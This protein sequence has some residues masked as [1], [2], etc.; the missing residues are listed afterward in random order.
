MSVI[1][2]LALLL[3]AS[4]SVSAAPPASRLFAQHPQYSDVAMSPDGRHLAIATPVDKR[5]DLVVLDLAGKTEPKRL[6]Y[7]TN[8]HIIRPQFVSDTRIVVGKGRKPDYLEGTVSIGELNATNIDLSEPK[9]LFAYQEDDGNRKGRRKDQGFARVM[10]RLGRI[11]NDVLVEFQSWDRSDNSTYIYRVDAGTGE[12]KLID[13]VRM[14]NAWVDADHDGRPRFAFAIDENREYDIRYRPTPESDWQDLP[15][16][17]AG[18]SMVLLAFEQDNN[19]AYASISD[20]G[21]PAALYRV[22]FKSGTREKLMANGDFDVGSLM[23]A[24]F[25]KTPFAIYAD[26]PKPSVKYLDPTSEWAKLHAGLMK[27]FPGNLV[28]FSE[29]SRDEGKVLLAVYGDRNPGQYYLLDRKDNSLTLVYELFESLPPE[30][31]A[32]MRPIE[33]GTPDGV[34]LN[35]FLTVPTIGNA[36]FPMIVM[37]HGGPFGVSDHWGF[38]SDVQFLASRGYAVLQV[39]FRGSGGRGDKF[40]R[41]GFR[42]WGGKMMDDIAAGTYWAIAEKIADPE[43]ICTYGTSFGGYAAMMQPIRY[44]DLYRCAVGYVGVYDLNLMTKTG[45]INDTKSGR[46]YIAEAIGTDEKS[47]ADQSPV[48][49]VDKLKVP[50]LLIHGKVDHRVPIAHLDAL[51]SALKNAG[52]PPE[53]LVKSAEAH[54]FYSVDNRIELYDTLERFLAKHIGKE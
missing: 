40:E 15:S 37:A 28:A 4:A 39:N 9:A 24:G 43:R 46:N 54:G 1:R 6:R 21:E 44:P 26:T 33:V 19:M 22:D 36:P 18:L 27:R 10:S 38:D 11:E 35:G 25:D 23:V 45:D 48:D 50:V 49:L 14:Y 30:L 47:L 41:S 32:P 42:E 17:I 29:F 52:R 5:T 20:N 12:R 13:T 8:E 16:S 51:E 7:G 3:A 34:V 53:T 31:L 2:L